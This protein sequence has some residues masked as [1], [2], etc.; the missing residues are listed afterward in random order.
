[1]GNL[2]TQHSWD[3][4]FLVILLV[5]R[6]RWRK[7]IVRTY[8]CKQ[9]VRQNPKEPF[10]G[11]DF[12]MK[13]YMDVPFL[14]ELHQRYGDTY[15][16]SPWISTSTTC[17]IAPGNLRAINLSKDFGVSPMRL[18]GMEYFCGRGFITTD[19]DTWRDARKLLKPSFELNNV[20]KLHT[21]RREVDVFLKQ[22]PGDGSTVDL[23]PLLYV[24]F[25]NSALHFVLGVHP[26]KQASGVPLTADG[27]VKS[28]HDALFYSMLR[29]FVDTCTAA[30]G[31][32]DYYINQTFSEID[33][34]K[35]KSLI[36]ALSA[37]T[38]DLDFIRSQVI[39]A[40]MA[41]QDTTS[42]LLTNALFRL[43]RHPKYWDRLRTEFAGK[44]EDDL[45]AENL[46]ALRLHPIFPLLGRIA[47]RDTNLPVGGGPSHD[48]PM[49]IQ[50][51]SMVV[52]DYYAL[53]RNPEVFGDDVETF[54][55]E[56]WDSIKPT[57]W[58]VL[59]FGGGNRACLGQQK[60]TIEASYVLA[61]LAQVIELKMTCK[62]AN[63]CKVA[64]YLTEHL[65]RSEPNT[66]L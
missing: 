17:T 29:K 20:R 53:H 19:G 61:R 11:F 34:P 58:E 33:G 60:A 55:P 10:Y 26:S 5:Q 13:M 35:D 39:Q 41:A 43:A 47:L 65:A 2:S 48:H 23:Q 49:F 12:Q 15:E 62:S 14:Y 52:M 64:V 16:V 51:G 37:Q 4:F 63:G 7:A 42:E 28:F 57:Q 54:R 9:A 50:K 56:R 59:G 32:L 8:G 25:M 66:G 44:S 27:F 31:F 45:S 21:L 30:H 3:L 6:Q 1:M 36:Q 18:P 38:N 46:L 22:L 40:M 24:M